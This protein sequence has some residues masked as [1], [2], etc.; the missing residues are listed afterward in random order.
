MDYEELYQ[1]L[2]VCAKSVKEKLQAEQNTYK[3]LIK[4]NE[5]G[6]LKSLLKDLTAMGDL[7]RAHEEL[8]NEM[9]ERAE[10][11]DAGAYMEDG[12]FARQMVAY[13][14]SASVDVKGEYP[15]YEIFPYKIKIDSENQ[16]IYIDRKKMQCVRPQYLV[17]ELKQ[18]REKLMK[19]AFNASAFLNE[20]ADAYD[21]AAALKPHSRNSDH[22]LLLKDLYRYMVPMQRH[23]KDYDMQSFAFDLARLFSSD[24]EY[25]KDGRQYQFGGS[26]QSSQLIRF[27]DQDGN[28][29]YK[30]TI[31]FYKKE[32]DE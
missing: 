23:R 11:F 28:E 25:T 13:C 22:D 1:Q 18:S 31:R 5:K 26:R 19:A 20:L 21:K 3:S 2:Q 9:K 30:A 29:Q 32:T 7:L 14:E 15:T 8:I 12:D 10:S 27:I 24:V 4:N 17:G 6:D 16:D